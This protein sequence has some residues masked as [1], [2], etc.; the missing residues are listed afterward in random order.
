MSPSC[1]H[2]RPVLLVLILDFSPTF[3]PDVFLVPSNY[4]SPTSPIKLKTEDASIPPP[5]RILPIPGDLNYPYLGGSRCYSLLSLPQL[6]SMLHP[7]RPLFGS[8]A[9]PDLWL[10]FAE[11]K[12]ACVLPPLPFTPPLLGGSQS[13]LP[14]AFSSALTILVDSPPPPTS[15]QA[16]KDQLPLALPA[17]LLHATPYRLEICF[18]LPHPHRLSVPKG[19]RAYLH[20]GIP[21]CTF[22]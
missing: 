13:R 10:R 2:S 1:L 17:F 4:T 18:L 21:S 22:P 15:A 3:I 19:H 5:K 6:S 16:F 14:Q 8:D 11:A 12:P 7:Q 9:P 20:L